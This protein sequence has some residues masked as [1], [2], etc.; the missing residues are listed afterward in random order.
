MRVLLV[1]PKNE[2]LL[3]E[4]TCF[5]PLGLLYLAS[6]LLKNYHEVGIIDANA[7][8]IHDKDI[9]QEISKYNPD[10]IGMGLC[11]EM[12]RPV[13]NITKLIKLNFPNIK[14]VLGGSHISATP[15]N[16]LKEFTHVDFLLRNES[17]YTIIELCDSLRKNKNLKRI[18]G[19]SYR[20]KNKIVHNPPRPPIR[21]ID[22][23]EFPARELLIDAY[24]KKKYFSVVVKE[25]PV[26][27]VITSRGCP[28]SCGFCY[29]HDKFYR[30]RSIKNVLDEILYINS[31]KVRNIEIL[32][33]LFTFNRKRAIE[34]FKA[35]KKENLDITFRIKSRVDL[36]DRELVA[37]AKSANVYMISYGAESGVQKILNNM[38]KKITPKMIENAC[39]ITN[40]A[41]IKCMT[42]WIVGYP[43]E[44]LHTINKTI[45]FIIKIKPFAIQV[46]PLLPYPNTPVYN[47][48][49]SKGI[50]MGDWSV[51]NE[52][53]PWI[54]LPWIKNYED[55]LKQAQL[56]K[57]KVYLRP[58]YILTFFN[59]LI[60]NFNPKL[61]NYSM[62]EFIKF[63]RLG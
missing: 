52:T 45:K 50:L 1:N 13:Y 3:L 40:E 27:G 55:L 5:P 12:L 14:I 43:G 62:S 31:Y 53:C 26:D 33:D 10:I 54:K 49:K 35:I 18:K 51:K 63:F 59:Q 11:S 24:K 6:S 61:I 22:E 28:Y 60:N 25:R 58:Y 8:S 39:K 9:I 57:N 34:I 30:A 20:I 17:E 29:N 36:V 32:D 37:K 46:R 21:N 16:V 38:D 23:I 47:F 2:S 7:F 4:Q 48:A 19:I 56:I 44:T 41:K 15:D 42:S